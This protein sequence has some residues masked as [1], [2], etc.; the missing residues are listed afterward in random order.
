M[1]QTSMEAAIGDVAEIGLVI[2]SRS[3]DAKSIVEKAKHAKETHGKLRKRYTNAIA[4]AAAA[5]EDAEPLAV[6]ADA[7]QLEHDADAQQL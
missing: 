7:T 1:M 2:E 4:E 6:A 3:G 5:K